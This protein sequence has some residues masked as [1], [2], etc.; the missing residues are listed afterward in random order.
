LQLEQQLE[1]ERQQRGEV[2]RSRRRLEGDSRST[3]ETL[4][5]M[6]KRRGGLEDVLKRWAPGRRHIYGQD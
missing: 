1:Q 6:E 5:E 2:E 3:L 4:G